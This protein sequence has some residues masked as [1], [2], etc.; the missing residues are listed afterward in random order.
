MPKG[1]AASEYE[2]LL[3]DKNIRRWYDNVSRGSI[4]TAHTWLRRLGLI[5]KKFHKTPQQIASMNTKDRTNFVLDVITQLEKD[6]TSGSYIAN[7]VKALKNWL[8][9]NGKPIQQKIKIHGRNDLVKF[10]DEKPPNPEELGKIFN[11]ADLRARAASAI[12]AFSGTRLEILGDYLGTDGLKL[13]D[14]EAS[15]K[16]NSVEFGNTPMMIT[17][18]KNLSKTG[19]QFFT[20]L[21]EE[22]CNYLKQYLEWRLRRG[23]QLAPNSPLITPTQKRLAG[24]HIRTINIGDL[25]RKPIREAGFQWRPYV[26]R[27]YFD[28]RLMMAEADGLTI[29]DWRV[30][31]MGHHGDME[32]TYTVNKGL[33]RDVV[34]K[35]RG[36]YAK[37]AEKYLNTARKEKGPDEML[38][39]MNR[40]FLT[41][42]GYKP[43]EVDAMGSL[44]EKTEE[45]MQ[46]LI[47]QKQMAA[48]GLN[49]NGR[50]KIVPAAE[51]RQWITQGWEYVKDLNGSEAIIRLPDS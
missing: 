42:I 23:E 1:V 33:P 48:L 2:Y 12:I 37:A 40:Q 49:G 50:Q 15:I 38:A 10:A 25:I 39:R 20:F 46:Q 35:M 51:V 47:K 30:F 9:F 32:A 28:T 29:K 3:K 19:N 41:L 31:W 44:S 8:E 27:R 13:K 36:S 21:C 5:H 14:I 43:E 16:S 4:I 24:E 22:G 45:E 17:V 11:A 18:R 34:E 6:G 7:I 26:L